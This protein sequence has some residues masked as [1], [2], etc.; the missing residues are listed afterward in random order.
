M[1]SP[2]SAFLLSLYRKARALPH[3]AFKAWVFSE[4]GCYL[5]FDSGFW[6]RV[7]VTPDG[8][9]IHDQHLDRQRLDRLSGYVAEGLWRED[10][11]MHMALEKP[12]MAAIMA[13]SSIPSA[14]LRAFL[15]KHQQ[16][17]VLTW[18]EIDN[19]SHVSVGFTMF[20]AD[21]M[22]PFQA[23][24]R[25]FVQSVGAHVIEAWTQNWFRD[26]DAIAPPAQKFGY[27]QAILTSNRMLTALDDHFVAT[28]HLEWPAWLG[29]SL[30]AALD[31]HVRKGALLPFSGKSIVARF[32][33][34]SDGLL[35]LQL[36]PRHALDD[37][38]PRKREAAIMF[39]A[40]ALQSQVAERMGLSASTINNYLSDIYRQLKVKDKAQLATMI[41]YLPA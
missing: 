24:D 8:P 31:A 33:P 1:D 41:A 10:P 35:R 36:R 3:A 37:L 39:A 6:L 28:A 32:Q 14:R 2:A 21:A 18:L 20:R 17:H 25:Q 11:F 34:L 16:A 13:A 40:G 7:T 4:L 15:S 12:N 9:L 22:R 23:S 26:L 30:P 29:P 38:P 5:S 19:V 27:S